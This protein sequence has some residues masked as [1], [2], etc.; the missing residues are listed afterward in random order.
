VSRGLAGK[1]RNGVV[2]GCVVRLFSRLVERCTLE[3][4]ACYMMLT[5]RDRRV[6]VCS[7]GRMSRLRVLGL[8][9]CG[10]IVPNACDVICLR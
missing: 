2:I 9:Y 10:G 6:D 8:L 1:V 7:F 5:L 4:F 3:A